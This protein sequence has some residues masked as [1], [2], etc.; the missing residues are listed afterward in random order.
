MTLIALEGEVCADWGPFVRS[1]AQTP[2]AM[3]LG[4]ANEV[5]SY[6]PMARIIR[7]GGY[8]GDHAHRI[9]LVP[10]PFQPQMEVEL[11]RLVQR[12][13][14]QLA[15]RAP[16]STPGPIPRHDLLAD[17]SEADPGRRITT[18]AQWEPRRQAIVSAV[19]EVTGP[20]PGAAFRVPLDLTVLE[21]VRLDHYTRK[22][23]AY[24]VDP[25]DRVESYLLVPHNLRGPAPAIVALH[26]TNQYGKEPVAGLV[27]DFPPE[28]RAKMMRRTYGHELAERGYV[29]ITPDYWYYGKYHL[30]TGSYDPYQRGYASATMKGVWNHMQAIDVLETLPQVDASRIGAIGHSLGG[31]NTLFWGC[32]ICG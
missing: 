4:Y 29:V 15:D 31:Y 16:P 23:I 2:Y 10:A 11:T 14:A 21:E 20:V 24:N 22:K 5:S 17:P 13:I 12:A 3:T 25:Y 26:G 1:L 28:Y 8:E 19:Q 7:E 30:Q 18:P 9:Y 27:E 32:S 6:I